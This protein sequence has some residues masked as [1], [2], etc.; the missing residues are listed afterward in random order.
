MA[1]KPLTPPNPTSLFCRPFRAGTKPI[2][3]PAGDGKPGSAHRRRT[4][5]LRM[6]VVSHGEKCCSPS[7]SVR[8]GTMVSIACSFRKAGGQQIP[9]VSLVSP[10]T[11]QDEWKKEKAK[12]RRDLTSTTCLP[13]RSWTRNGARRTRTGVACPHQTGTG[14]VGPRLLITCLLRVP[15]ETIAHPT[16][17]HKPTCS[18]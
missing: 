8:W 10:S 18:Y 12:G 3:R 1:T 2:V 17:R 13:G 9:E 7:E 16:W 14:L 11:C 6:Q 15:P 4:A 5:K